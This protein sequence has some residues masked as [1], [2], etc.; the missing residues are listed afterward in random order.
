MINQILKKWTE[1]IWLNQVWHLL[2][3][4]QFVWE[5]KVTSPFVLGDVNAK[6]KLSYLQ[7][8]QWSE[9]RVVVFH[10]CT[11]APLSQLPLETKGSHIVLCP[12]NGLYLTSFRYIFILRFFLWTNFDFILLSYFWLQVK[13]KSSFFYKC[14][15]PFLHYNLPIL[16]GSEPVR[17]IYKQS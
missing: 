8:G 4:V 15:K 17:R 7:D 9:H 2:F 10:Y 1:I 12:S 14:G 16:I 13:L 11:S 6:S 3:S 5:I